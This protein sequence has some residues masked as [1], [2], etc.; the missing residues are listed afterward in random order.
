MAA[1]IDG[2]IKETAIQGETFDSLSYR[3][4][5]EEHMSHYIRQY[6]EQYSDIVMFNGGEELTIPILSET[7]SKESLA[8]WRR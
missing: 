6:N 4:Y 5:G 1:I 3:I 7:E 8:P 2:F